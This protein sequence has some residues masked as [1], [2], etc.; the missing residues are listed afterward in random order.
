MTS[1]V[2]SLLKVCDTAFRSGDRALYSAA[3]ADLKKGVINPK[4]DYNKRI[5][6]HIVS[7][8][9]Q[10]VWQGQQSI[11]NY[12]GWDVTPGDLSELLAEELNSFFARFET[13]Q[14]HSS[15]PAL[16]PPPSGSTPTTAVQATKTTTSSNQHLL[17]TQ[18][19]PQ[20]EQSGQ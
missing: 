18:I 5:E 19:S 2:R 17:I 13:P 1:Q 6:S 9:P 3:R 12:R 11:T 7:N 4:A 8:R 20:E 15:A 16:P 14:R 10:E